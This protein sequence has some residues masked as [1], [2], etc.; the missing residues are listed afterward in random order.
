MEKLILIAL[1]VCVATMSGQDKYKIEV[2]FAHSGPFQ[3][4]PPSEFSHE[5]T[6][7][8]Y[9]FFGPNGLTFDW[10]AL[11]IKTHVSVAATT[12]DNQRFRYEIIVTNDKTAKDPIHSV[13][14]SW[15]PLQVQPPPEFSVQSGPTGWYST[16][17]SFTSLLPPLMTST[18]ALLSTF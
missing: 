13:T 8:G 18:F 5:S 17:S 1:F 11:K 6:A 7:D 15:R 9:R 14:L 10:T 3:E 16:A 12:T 4:S 2:D